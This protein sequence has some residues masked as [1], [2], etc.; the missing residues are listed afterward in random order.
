MLSKLR[1]KW[2][3]LQTYTTSLYRNNVKRRDT[4]QILSSWTVVR[5]SRFISF[6]HHL[7]MATNTNAAAYHW[8]EFWPKRVSTMSI[9]PTCWRCV[10]SGSNTT[11]SSWRP[12]AGLSHLDLFCFTNGSVDVTWAY[13]DKSF[14][15][16]ILFSFI[17]DRR[18]FALYL[19]TSSSSDSTFSS[20]RGSEFLV[21]SAFVYLQVFPGNS[22]WC[23]K[24]LFLYLCR[25]P[26]S[27]PYSTKG[28]AKIWSNL[29]LLL[30]VFA[31]TP[32]TAWYLLT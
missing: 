14:S 9:S 11:S 7:P 17:L 30:N 13:I 4:K 5:D 10:L 26:V 3:R 19:S 24:S 2:R 22:Y 16:S 28:R 29:I 15:A 20:T 23:S 21:L 12:F 1:Q 18:S 8:L 6:T 32:Q 31:N 27:L 25:C